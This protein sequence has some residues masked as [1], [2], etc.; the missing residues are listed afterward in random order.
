MANLSRREFLSS[1]AGAIA[2]MACLAGGV[3][4]GAITATAWCTP[5]RRGQNWDDA[6]AG[7]RLLSQS[8]VD[9]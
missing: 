7:R 3:C 1:A 4:P 5:T 9:E 2:A 6:S 8:I